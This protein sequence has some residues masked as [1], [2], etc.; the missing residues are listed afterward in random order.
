MTYVTREVIVERDRNGKSLSAA[1]TADRRPEL[2]CRDHAIVAPQMP[3]LSRE[4]TARDGG[5]N[6]YRGV[7]TVATDAVVDERHSG[8]CR[9]HAC[10]PA[11]EDRMHHLHALADARQVPGQAVQATASATTGPT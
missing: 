10:T 6:L 11:G 9:R 2:A 8:A 5:E 3:Q 7:P 1:A 4:G